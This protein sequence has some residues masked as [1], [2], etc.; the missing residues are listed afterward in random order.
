MSNEQNT[1]L[2]EYIAGEIS[3]RVAVWERNYDRENA[4]TIAKLQKEIADGRKAMDK[5]EINEYWL[6]QYAEV[7]ADCADRIYDIQEGRKRMRDT[8]SEIIELT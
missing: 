4:E 2:G 5:D 3:E 6:G 1:Q 7:I 8:V